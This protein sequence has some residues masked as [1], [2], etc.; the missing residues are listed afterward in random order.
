MQLNE[1]YIEKLDNL[2]SWIE[3]QEALT[4]EDIQDIVRTLNDLLQ[5]FIDDLTDGLGDSS[6]PAEF[7]RKLTI[8]VD[9][10]LDAFEGW[11]D[12]AEVGLQVQYLS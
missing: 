6:H 2:I 3:N 12:I 5:E 11:L 9:L 1:T 10:T 8:V 4:G 7:L